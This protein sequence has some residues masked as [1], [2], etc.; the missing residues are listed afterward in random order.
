M[1][2]LAKTLEI[3]WYSFGLTSIEL[4]SFE[5]IIDGLVQDYSISSALAM[6][7]LLLCTKPLIGDKPLSEPMVTR[8][9]DAYL[10]H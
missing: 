4:N 3:Q 1:P 9:T 10:Q 8:F 2:N 7:I 5:M 6:E